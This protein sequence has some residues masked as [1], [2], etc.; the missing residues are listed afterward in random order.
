MSV[1]RACTVDV[2][3]SLMF[4]SRDCLDQLILSNRD[5]FSSLS[6]VCRSES[7]SGELSVAVEELEGDWTVLSSL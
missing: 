3:T 2:A 7:G 4:L 1:L 5:L 6:G